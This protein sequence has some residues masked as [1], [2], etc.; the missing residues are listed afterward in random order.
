[1]EDFEK[2]KKMKHVKYIL[3]LRV[4]NLQVTNGLN[5]IVS[6]LCI[7]YKIIRILQDYE[8]SSSNFWTFVYLLEIAKSSGVSPFTSFGFL[9]STLSTMS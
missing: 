8:G 2:C 9:S 3:K 7:S 4:P 6:K 5:M 1:M